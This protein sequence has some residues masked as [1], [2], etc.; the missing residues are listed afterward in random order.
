MNAPIV[1]TND[2][3]VSLLRC[4]ALPMAFICPGS[5]RKASIRINTSN[6]AARLGSAAHKLAE[7][8]PT[9]GAIDYSRA[10]E[11]AD[12]YQ[13]DENELRFCASRAE[14]LWPK[15]R[16]S[17]PLAS[18][19]VGG[20]VDLEIDG[21]VLT[22]TLDL[23]SV[24]ADVARLL[25]W[26]FG[27]LDKNYVQQLNG[28]AAIVF[29][30]YP[31]VNELTATI[32]WARDQDIENYHITR[33][34]SDAWV[35]RIRNEVIRW[36]GVYHPHEGCVH[37]QRFHECDAA[38]KLARS[39]VEVIGGLSIDQIEHQLEHMPGQQIIELK[40]KAKMVRE[41]AERAEAA[42]TNLAIRKGEIVGEDAMLTVVNEPR[43]ELDPIR[44]WP[45]VEA[46][47]FEEQDWAA[48]VKVSVSKLED[49]V[50]NKAGR[51][52]GAA[53]IRSLKQ[54]LELA[55]AVELPE[56]LVVKE[57]RL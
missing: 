38:N 3:L 37:C 4:S 10:R 34:Q 42:I 15:I 14:Q 6:E 39:N 29:K 33:E 50:K 52:N 35:N 20:E 43:R 48:V 27:R 46:L 18:S 30:K 11:L 8:L 12:E 56:R 2:I 13:C 49:R 26:K 40:R 53:A 57:K 21:L 41:I 22:G 44:T 7:S 1:A 25:D 36:D 47:G 19:E 16:D 17:Y 5:I 31:K 51:G 24:W 28:Y 55:G 32:A 54:K 23:L 45:I 9:E